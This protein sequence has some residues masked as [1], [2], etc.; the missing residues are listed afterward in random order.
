MVEHIF[1]HDYGVLVASILRR[2]GSQHLETIEDAVQ[3]AMMQA[4]EHWVRH[5]KPDNPSAWLYQVAYR[6][7]LSELRNAQKRNQLLTEFTQ[8]ESETGPPNI[9][10]PL[11]GEMTDSM[12]RMLFI[13]CHEAL[14]VQSQL[15]FTLKS[16][17]GFTVGEIA[18]RLM[19]TEANTYKR[20]SRARQFFENK[21]APLDELAELEAAKRLPIVH[22][23]LYL[24]FTEGYLSSQ[25]DMAIR[26]DLC[27]EAV[28]LTS[29][30]SASALGNAPETTALLAL[31]YLQMSRMV[32]RQDDAGTLLLLEQQDRKLWDQKAIATGL[33][34]LQQSAQGD[35]ISRYHL[36]ASIAAEH[37]MAPSFA[38]TRWDRIVASYELLEKITKSPLIQLNKTIAIA[39]WQG[40]E[41]GLTN[42]HSAEHSG[43]LGKSFYWYAVKADLLFRLGEQES[44]N[45]A[46]KR[47]LALAPTLEIRKLFGKRFHFME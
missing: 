31:M 47:A 16:L 2:V 41:V 39:E 4:L 37:C 32:A 5:G 34:L 23:V 11:Q 20:F 17:C 3:F 27:E 10:V 43:W 28:R 21:A 30:L 44:A 9:D 46:A 1:R 8:V 14:P 35:C 29:L 24:V 15:V 36:E 25:N 45:D 7:V 22:H 6:K 19:I 38:E 13:A 26:T 18:Q 33:Y 42:L 40:P 12:L